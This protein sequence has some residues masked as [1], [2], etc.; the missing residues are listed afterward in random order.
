[1]VDLPALRELYPGLTRFDAWLEKKG[2]AKSIALDA[3][4]AQ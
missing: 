1:M 3:D 4:G 2:K